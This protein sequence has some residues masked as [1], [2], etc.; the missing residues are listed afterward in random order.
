M[1]RKVTQEEASLHSLQTISHAV[2][3]TT[4]AAELLYG[5]SEQSCYRCLLIC[6]AVS[7]AVIT[8]NEDISCN[9]SIISAKIPLQRPRPFHHSSLESNVYVPPDNRSTPEAGV[10]QALYCRSNSN[11]FKLPAAVAASSKG[12][13]YLHIQYRLLEWQQHTCVRHQKAIQ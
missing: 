5:R 6:A 11:C 1:I 10:I 8:P 3:E 12:P 9:R 13:T 7:M 2:N 4:L